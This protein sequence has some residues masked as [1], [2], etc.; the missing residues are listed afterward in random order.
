MYEEEIFKDG[1]S[2]L[3]WS[4]AAVKESHPMEPYVGWDGD[5][6]GIRVADDLAMLYQLEVNGEAQREVVDM[7]M[8]LW[9]EDRN[10]RRDVC[11][12]SKF[13]RPGGAF[14]WH[15]DLDYTNGQLLPFAVANAWQKGNFEKYSNGGCFEMTFAGLGTHLECYNDRGVVRFFNGNPVEWVRKEKNDPTIDH[16]DM[17]FCELRSLNP[18]GNATFPALAE[19]TGIVESVSA[20]FV[21]GVKCYRIK[22]WSGW[23]K[24]RSSFPWKLLVSAARIEGRYV[25]RTGDFVHGSA[26][27]FGTFQGENQD[28]PTICQMPFGDGEIVGDDVNM[29]TNRCDETAGTETVSVEDDGEGKD[30]AWMPRRHQ[31]YPDV[32]RFAG[33]LDPE[34]E[35]ALPKFVT[36]ADYRASVKGDLQEEVLLSRKELKAVLDQILVGGKSKKGKMRQKRAFAG[37]LDSIGIR[38]V[39]KDALTGERHVWC[40]VPS[41]YGGQYTRT[42][43]LAALDADGR[44]LRYS[45]HAGDWK[46][47]PSNTMEFTAMSSK[48]NG[49]ETEIGTFAEA[50]AHVGDMIKD[51][52]LVCGS[53]GPTSMLQAYCDERAEDGVQKFTVEWQVHSVKW[54]FAAHGI[55]ARQLMAMIA[56]YE[57]HGIEA[58]ETMTV[59]K[60]VCIGS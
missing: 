46:M 38:H 53:F 6:N 30:W 24:E 15:A 27:M 5:V 2:F 50:I 19:F 59:W 39:V 45:L 10:L 42:H 55:T 3:A 47:R 52:F 29:E 60:W 25:P 31:K 44:V 58:V 14:L 9:G 11:K 22:L 1:K 36:Y 54:Q 56:A 28:S 33:G 51:D 35:M 37:H 21:Q 34:V 32:Q 49:R 17:T 8:L 13:Y 12:V 57:E 20:E 4:M 40:C 41:S 23:P 43:L 7:H 16:Y 18:G 26:I 48:A